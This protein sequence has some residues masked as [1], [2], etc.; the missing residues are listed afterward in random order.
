MGVGGVAGPGN[1]WVPVSY[2][3]YRST[4]TDN[5]MHVVLSEFAW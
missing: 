1:Y 4:K 3:P 5:D 2:I